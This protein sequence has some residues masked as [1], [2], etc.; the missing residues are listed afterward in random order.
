MPIACVGLSHHTASLAV[1]ERLAFSRESVS[2]ALARVRE[3]GLR[4]I[5]IA[6]LSLVSTCNRTELYAAAADPSFRFSRAPELLSHLLL[7][8]G[9]P[10]LEEVRPCLYQHA[11]TEAVRHLCRVASGLDSMILG[12]AEVLGQVAAAHQTAVQAGTAGPILEAAFLAA[13]RAGRRARSE[14]GIC[15]NPVSIASEGV[16]LASEVAPPGA[17][18]LILGT[19]EMGRILGRVVGSRGFTRVEVIGRTAESVAA[20]AAGIAATARPWHELHDAVRDADL[21]LTCTAAP[22]PVITRELVQSAVAGRQTDRTLTLIDLAVPRDVEPEVAS[23]PGVRVYNID[24][25][26]P[27]LNGNLAGR[28]QEV[29]QVEAIVEEEV[30]LFQA[31]RHGAGLRPV[32]A[33]MHLRGEE[34]RRKETDRALRRMGCADPQVQ[35]QVEALSRAIVA[36]LLHHPSARLRM[37]TDPMRSRLYVGAVRDLF[38]LDPTPPGSAATPDDSA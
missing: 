38:G 27:R 36:K 15:R 32:L 35:R 26:Q 10:G 5:G 34:I 2:S 28:R 11:S 25:L 17:R 29:P 1:R 6:E 8:A 37:E 3:P 20:V 13:V 7:S 19:G 16:R 33:A 31:W 14:T 30:T 22:H 23:F 9:G 12:E 18:I 4:A 24:A 21:V